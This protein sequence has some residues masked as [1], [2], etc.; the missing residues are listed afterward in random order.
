MHNRTFFYNFLPYKL[1]NKFNLKYEGGEKEMNWKAAAL[2]VCLMAL[3]LAQFAQC[4][5]ALP[6]WA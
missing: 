6:M 1:F 5:W 3:C 2:T 4:N